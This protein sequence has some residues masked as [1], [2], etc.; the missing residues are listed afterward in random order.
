MANYFVI[1]SKFKPY[2]FDELIKPYQMYGQAYKEQEALIDAARE[3]EFSPDYLDQTQDAAAYNMYNTA[4]QNL[5][6]ASDELATKGLS[7]GLRG[8]LRTVAKDYQRT[9]GALNTAQAQLAAERDRRAK[10]GEDYVYQQDNLRIGDFLNGATPNQRSASLSGITK[11]IATEFATRAKSITKDTWQKA[12]DQNG[13]VIG[14]YYDVTTEQGLTAAQLDTI[15]SDSD[16][17]NRIMSDNSISKEEKDNLQ[18]FRDVISTK[19]QAIGYDAYTPD[20]QYKIDDAIVRGA[21]A[22]LGSVTH[23]Y[24][25]DRGYNP[26]GWANYN[27]QKDKYDAEK[28]E[29]EAPY[30][31]S[32]E[33]N[34]TPA[35]R[36][37]FKPGYSIKNGKLQYNNPSSFSSSGSGSSATYT[38][39]TPTITIHTNKGTTDYTDLNKARE[40]TGGRAGLFSSGKS[41]LDNTPAVAIEDITDP[42]IKR[43]LLNRINVA[44]K[45]VKDA[46]LDFLINENLP[47]L[48]QL[49]VQISGEKN[50]KDYVW[51]ISD[52]KV[53]RLTGEDKE[54]TSIDDKTL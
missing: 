37:G 49:T 43:A 2:S 25:A 42:E 12:M 27:L 53:Q 21:S 18:R 35:N 15:L 16:T 10:L 13:K 19:K 54:E 48:K 32:D 5:Q 31:H 47:Q 29:A 7:S 24:E 52:K 3:K 38:I 50:A 4:T 6:A 39:T 22:G 9:M 20:N 36:T 33:S 30:T 1:N 26:L 40:A 23:K 51:A 41:V 44:N 8:R 11:D 46:D 14:G 28:I 45:N 17:W 34:P